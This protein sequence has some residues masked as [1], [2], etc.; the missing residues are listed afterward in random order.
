MSFSVQIKDELCDVIPPTRGC[1]L[2]ELRA[3]LL[4]GHA[5]EKGNRV[6]QTENRKIADR[7]IDFLVD[8]FDT[9]LTIVSSRNPMRKDSTVYTVLLERRDLQ[10]EIAENFLADKPAPSDDAELS[11]FIR[12]AY[13]V[14]GSMSDPEK[15]YHLEFVVNS[16]E[17]AL[18]LAKIISSAN[19]PVKIIKRKNHYILYLKES[20]TIEDMLT[21]IGATKASLAIM[22]IKILKDV[23]NKVNRV[24]NCETANL[25]K[26]VAASARQIEDINLIMQKKGLDFLP[27]NLREVAAIRLENPE[28]SLNELLETLNYSISKS[29]LNHRLKRINAIADSLRDNE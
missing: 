16:H 15:E 21:L 14:C 24:T 13:L 23:R 3:L 17:R 11:S 27:D 18:D 26:T 12:G 25:D 8:E 29:G 20:E 19:I 22:D 1:M 10:K 4:F 5:F 2:I 7:L 6:L 9:F 28:L